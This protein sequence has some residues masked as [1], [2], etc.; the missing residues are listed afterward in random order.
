MTGRSQAHAPCW[1]KEYSWG[2]RA[3]VIYALGVCDTTDNCGQPEDLVVPPIIPQPDRASRPFRQDGSSCPSGLGHASARGGR[4]TPSWRR[5]I[6]AGGAAAAAVPGVPGLA[7]II[8]SR[9]GAWPFLVAAVGLALA[10]VVLNAVAA[11][12]QARQETR[13]RE[14]ERHGADVLADALARCIDDTHARAQNLSPV[15]EVGEAARVRTSASDILSRMLPA[16]LAVVS[17]A[18]DQESP[19]AERDEHQVL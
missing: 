8:V 13:R 7:W 10:A 6:L 19:P 18:P 11:M 5:W 2:T 14:I 4:E 15:G 1:K 16:V 12:Y 17:Q 3:L 9:P